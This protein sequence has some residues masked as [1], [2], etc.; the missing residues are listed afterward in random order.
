MYQ[1]SRYPVTSIIRMKKFLKRG[2]NISAGEILKICM[3]ISELNLHDV[4]VLEDQLIGV[5]VAYF[6]TL[7][8]AISNIKDTSKVNAEYISSI[9]D[10][11]FKNTPMEESEEPKETS[12]SVNNHKVVSDELDFLTDVFINQVSGELL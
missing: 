9:I 6:S 10:N 4:E 5:D 2:W 3:Q 12:V 1:G 8:S 11:I 7:I